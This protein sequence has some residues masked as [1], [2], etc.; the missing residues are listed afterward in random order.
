MIISG[1][2]ASERI[3]IAGRAGGSKNS[4][5]WKTRFVRLNS[6]PTH[7]MFYLKRKNADR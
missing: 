3:W 6:S 5:D 2:S 4:E 7:E 1:T